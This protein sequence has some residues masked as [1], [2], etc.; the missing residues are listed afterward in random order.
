[1]SGQDAASV[2]EVSLKLAGVVEVREFEDEQA[3]R[4]NFLFFRDWSRPLG[5]LGNLVL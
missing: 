2:N 3:E 1:M 4:I 5:Y